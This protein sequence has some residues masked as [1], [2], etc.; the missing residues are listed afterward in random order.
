M[1][2]DAVSML[3]CIVQQVGD[4]LE[5]I[6]LVNQELLPLCRVVHLLQQNHHTEISTA[7]FVSS[8]CALYVTCKSG[9]STRLLCKHRLIST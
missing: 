6:A 7:V 3:T 8:C 2:G 5:G 1:Q 9:S 4:D